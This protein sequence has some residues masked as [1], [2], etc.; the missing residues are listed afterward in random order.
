MSDRANAADEWRAASLRSA[1]ELETA[2]A[3][4]A[5]ARARHNHALA[6]G[7]SYA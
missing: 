6:E 1:G 5:I 7:A 4:L 3:S 2:T